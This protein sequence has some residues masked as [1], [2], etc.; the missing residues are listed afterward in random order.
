MPG[1]WRTNIA[2][3]AAYGQLG[4]LEAARNAVQQLLAVRPDFAVLAREELGK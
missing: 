1:F 3:A 2:L 4:E